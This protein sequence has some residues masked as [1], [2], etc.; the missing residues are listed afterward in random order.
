MAKNIDTKTQPT[1]GDVPTFDASFQQ[2]LEDLFK[3]RRDVRRFK[4]TPLSAELCSELL[5]SVNLAPSVGNSQPWRWVDVATTSVR[6]KVIACFETAN[7]QASEKYD[8]ETREHYLQLKLAGLREAPVQY[9]VFCDADTEQGR[10]LGRQTMPEM[11]R[12]STVLSVHTYWLT[13]RARGV[14][15]GWVS[16]LDP[17][18]VADV[19]E[20]PDTWQLVSYLCVGWPEE[21]H[22]VPELERANWEKR[23]PL[24]PYRR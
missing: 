7:T 3:W 12:Y 11:L 15:V 4:T 5:A 18:A 16:I 1:H 10:G 22:C 23:K 17:K 8:D 2:A 24:E 14:G 6:E 20:V 19:L 21:Q 13:A 9:A